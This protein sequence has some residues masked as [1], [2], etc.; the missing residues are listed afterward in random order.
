MTRAIV[1]TFS[2]MVAEETIRETIEACQ[3][4]ERDAF[5]ALFE[6]YKDRVYSVALR[7]SGDPAQAMDIAQDTF[8]HLFDCIRAF[9][10]ESSFDTW[11]Y[12][13]VAN[14]CLDRRRSERRMRPLADGL[15]AMLR[16]PDDSLRDL[17][18]HELR[19]HVRAAIDQLAPDQR[20]AVVLRYTE[21]LSYDQIGEVL[22]CSPG[23]VASRLHRAHKELQRRLA[24]IM[25]REGGQHV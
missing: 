7:F 24:R 20:L 21:G 3:R 15:L 8:V 16:S 14:R 10:G 2:G 17:L 11:V 4:G 13:M 23:T 18:K 9:R 6:A 19:G 12:R 25:K 1:Y 22:N 5:R